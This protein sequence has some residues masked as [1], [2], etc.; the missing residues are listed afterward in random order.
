MDGFCPLQRARNTGS[1]VCELMEWRK[2][3]G[4]GAT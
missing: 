1:S 2:C 3:W 4:R